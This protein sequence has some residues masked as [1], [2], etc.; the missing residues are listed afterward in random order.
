MGLLVLWRLLQPPQVPDKNVAIATARDQKPVAEDIIN[1]ILGS[2][3]R[4]VD[5]VKFQT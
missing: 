3:T 4:K 5:F 1:V 2:K